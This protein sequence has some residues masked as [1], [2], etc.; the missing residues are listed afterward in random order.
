[1]YVQ[2]HTSLGLKI[3]VQVSPQIQMYLTPPANH[4]GPISGQRLQA[5]PGL[6]QLDPVA[7]T[8]SLALRSLWEQ[9]Q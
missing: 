7:V 9:Q 3:Q 6:A 1:M 8:S 4:M 2:V 5:K